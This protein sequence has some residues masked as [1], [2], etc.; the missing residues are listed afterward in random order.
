MTD[1]HFSTSSQDAIDRAANGR[2]ADGR[3]AEGAAAANSTVNDIARKLHEA[4]DRIT[5]HASK[6]ERRMQSA[7]AEMD[8]LLEQSRSEAGARAG[9]LSERVGDYVQEHPVASLG[10]AFGAGLLVASLLR[11]NP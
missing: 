6:A 3:A 7:S 9:N 10:I 11:R 4:I 1:S 8:D 5:V 2:A